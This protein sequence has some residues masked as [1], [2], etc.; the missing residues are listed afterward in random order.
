MA[1]PESNKSIVISISSFLAI[2]TMEAAEGKLFRPLAYTKTFALIASL[3]VA[4]TIIPP[5]AQILFT[6]R[7]GHGKIRR[8]INY[9]LI[10]LGVISIFAINWWFGLLLIFLGLFQ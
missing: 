4:L 5:F 1:S 3:I 2:F 9:V 10:V 6:S 7:L 8:F